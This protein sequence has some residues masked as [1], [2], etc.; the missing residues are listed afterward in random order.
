MLLPSVG[1]QREDVPEAV[2][3]GAGQD[4]LHADLSLS[5]L[6]LTSI[7]LLVLVLV[8]LLISI[9]ALCCYC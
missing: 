2:D 1:K 5:M 8:S 4:K 9:L 6:S 7:V 3:E